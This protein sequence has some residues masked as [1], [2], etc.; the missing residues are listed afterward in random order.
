MS[1]ANRK[2]IVHVVEDLRVGGLERVIQ[3]I[4]LGLDREKYDVRVWCLA[5]GG[6]VA[7]ELSE[8]GIPVKVLGLKSYYNPRRILELAVLFRRQVST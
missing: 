6:E 2:T 3:T 5:G 4:V 8:Q 1:K 7:D